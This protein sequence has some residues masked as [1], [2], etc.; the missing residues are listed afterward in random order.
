MILQ[1]PDDC[2]TPLTIGALKFQ[3]HRTNKMLSFK[4]YCREWHKKDTPE[5]IFNGFKPG[6]GFIK[7]KS[8]IYAFVKITA[9]Q[10]NTPIYK[11]ILYLGKAKYLRNRL[12][13][14]FIYTP[15]IIDKMN[16]NEYLWFEIY[17][18]YLEKPELSERLLIEKLNPLYNTHFK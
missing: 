7:N 3:S 13:N 18:W 6:D 17:V 5:L 9:K 1:F 15:Y 11:R 2:E 10:E 8:G 4:S 12:K 14:H 16:E